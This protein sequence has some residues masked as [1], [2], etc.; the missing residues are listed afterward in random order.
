MA[1]L[2]PLSKFITERYVVLMAATA[3]NT[4]SHRQDVAMEEECSK[5]SC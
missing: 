4:V 1:A 2:R 5:L 3:E